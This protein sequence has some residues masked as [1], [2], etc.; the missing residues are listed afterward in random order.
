MEILVALQETVTIMLAVRE[1][2]AQEVLVQMVF[3]IH[4]R[5]MVDQADQE[6]HHLL[7]NLIH[8]TVI[9][10]EVV[11]VVDQEHGHLVGLA[12]MV[13]VDQEEVEMEAEQDTLLDLVEE[14]SLA[15][16]TKEAV[17]ADKQPEHY[18]LAAVAVL[19]S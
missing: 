1:V 16:Q 17:E 11:E 2:A 3:S 18:L 12:F 8:L 10:L 15:H 9:Y 7:H 19:A 13:L 14:V 4:H 5:R 6:P